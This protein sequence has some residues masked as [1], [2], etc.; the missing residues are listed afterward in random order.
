V[1][2]LA[3]LRKGAIYLRTFHPQFRVSQLD[4]LLTV[5][6]K[7][8]QSQ[9]DLALACDLTLAA[10]SRAIDALGTSGRRDGKGSRLGFLRTERDPTDDRFVLVFLTDK[11][12]KMLQT[13]ADIVCNE[14]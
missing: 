10:I 8:G 13:L 12:K 1:H 14:P 9:T 2:R 3:R 7:Q 11:G 6:A 5:A 4:L